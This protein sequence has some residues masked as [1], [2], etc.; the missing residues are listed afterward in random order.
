[1]GFCLSRFASRAYIYFQGHQFVQAR[2]GNI[3]N[4]GTMWN[5][6]QSQNEPPAPSPAQQSQPQSQPSYTPNAAPSSRPA[7]PAA[8][9]LACLGATIE[10]K[11]QISGDEDLQVDGKVTGPIQLGGQ[12]LT[13]GRTGQLNSEISAREVIVY[14][15]VTGNLRARDRVEIKKDGSVVG[16]ITTARISV[17]DGAYFKGRIEID[18]PKSHGSSEPESAEVPVGATN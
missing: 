14:G 1:M 4:G 10:L 18:R 3:F 9:N 2:L 7:A 15:K 12:K 17:E 13:V 11:G 8:R 5:S 6:R 16:D